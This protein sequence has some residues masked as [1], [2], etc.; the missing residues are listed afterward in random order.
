MSFKV[1]LALGGG[2]ARGLAHLGVIRALVKAE[3]PINI[4]S[5]TSIGAMVAAIYAANPDIDAAIKTISAYIDSPDFDRTRLELI[6][7]S[8]LE[9]KNYFGTLKKYVKSGLFFAASIRQSSFISEAT[10]KQNLEKI[11]P[12]GNI[13]DCTVKLGLV[14]MNLDLAKEEVFTSGNIIQRV[15]ASCAIP[16]I[17]PPIC[18]EN[19][20]YVDGSWINPIPVSIAKQ[21]G[22]KFVIAVDVAPGMAKSQKEMNGFEVTLRAAEGSRNCLKGLR[23][24]NADIV[25]NIDLTDIHWADFSQLKKCLE[26]GEQT[27]QKKIGVIKN[28]L[29][30]KRIKSG[31]IF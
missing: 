27:I 10:F 23:L 28:R 5:G 8:S 17:F 16:G 31:I 30:W 21:L 4:I 24:A 11:L 13:E 1:G 26:Q 25:L 12:K 18:I 19:S 2:A 29:F 14:T 7:E 22:A 15:M 3:I 9:P 20:H 6:K